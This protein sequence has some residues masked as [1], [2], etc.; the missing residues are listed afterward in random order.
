MGASKRTA[1]IVAPG[2]VKAVAPPEAPAQ[3]KQQKEEKVRSTCLHSQLHK[4]KLCAY[5]LKG[6][7]Q[8]GSSC[9]FAHSC[10]EL[11]ATPDLRKTRLCMSFM[12][13]N[14]CEDP[15][16]PFAHGEDELRST[17]MFFKKTLCIWNEKGKC[18][19]G[20][21]C[22]FAHGIGELRASLQQAAMKSKAT[23]N[24][25]EKAAAPASGAGKRRSKA[26][27]Q[28]AA[29]SSGQET[30]PMKVL[31]HSNFAAPAP[32]PANQNMQ[33]ELDVL[34]QHIS[35]L[36]QRCNEIKYQMLVPDMAQL[37]EMGL[38]GMK[39]S[40]FVPQFAGDWSANAD[41]VNMMNAKV[42][43]MLLGGSDPS[44]QMSYVPK[45]LQGI[46]IPK[47]P[48]FGDDAEC[49]DWMQSLPVYPAMGA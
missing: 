32:L 45:D 25:V 15:D 48:G 28:G 43:A 47:P 36:S 37:E 49:A 35:A 16:C 42:A 9:A 31:P 19:N 11:Q 30:E 17:D 27:M 41:M 13:G 2:L 20:D 46:H 1:G 33:V 7:C 22:R 23:K 10:T 39:P 3:E 12:E 38:G 5:H 40:A 18:R 34:R 8:Y 44:A 14:G 6:N 24:A 4:T 29:G 21:Q 26:A